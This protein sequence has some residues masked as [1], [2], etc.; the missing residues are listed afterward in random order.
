MN[1]Y[2]VYLYPFRGSALSNS[3]SSCPSNGGSYHSGGSSYPSS[4]SLYLD[5]GPLGQQILTYHPTP[6]TPS[7]PMSRPINIPWQAGTQ[8][9]G[10]YFNLLG[11]PGHTRLQT[12]EGR[13]DRIWTAGL[14]LLWH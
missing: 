8:P 3:G 13:V 6:G 12:L 9:G 11:V 7:R 1:P 2:D 14:I 4:R 5:G 10:H